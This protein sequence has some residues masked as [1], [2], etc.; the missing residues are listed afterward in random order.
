M[1]MPYLTINSASGSLWGR[2]SDPISYGLGSELSI[3]LPHYAWNKCV[4]RGPAFIEFWLAA[5]A[6]R[7][8]NIRSMARS[9]IAIELANG[10]VVRGDGMRNLVCFLA[11]KGHVTGPEGYYLVRF[12]GDKVECGPDI[13]E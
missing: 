6:D 5:T 3:T 11:S 4:E 13:D 2:I 10:T 1:A 12:E 8:N 9:D 7:A